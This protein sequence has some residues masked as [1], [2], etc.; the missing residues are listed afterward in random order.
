MIINRIKQDFIPGD[1]C[2][3]VTVATHHFAFPALCVYESHMIFL[4]MMFI[5]A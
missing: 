2:I 5:A 4:Q 3:T 1:T